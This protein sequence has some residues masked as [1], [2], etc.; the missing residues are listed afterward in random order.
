MSSHHCHS[1]LARSP[2][3]CQ[4]APRMLLTLAAVSQ[5]LSRCLEGSHE[6]QKDVVLPE[7]LETSL[8]PRASISPAEQA[9]GTVPALSPPCPSLPTLNHPLCSAEQWLWS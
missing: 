5:P 6:Q 3:Q 7:G 9:P 4:P 1:G 8:I 2:D